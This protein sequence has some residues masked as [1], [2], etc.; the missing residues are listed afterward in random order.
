MSNI[1]D[2]SD[3]VKG[4]VEAVP[5]YQDL[6]QPAMVELGKGVHTLSKT[7]HIALSP[8]AALVWS[9]DQI[10]NYIQK[11]LEKKLEDV[12]T[13]QIVSPAPEIAVPAI[14]A[15]RYTGHREELRE[16]FS[17]LLAKSMNVNTAKIAHPSFVEIIKQLSPDEARIMKLFFNQNPWPILKMRAIQK[18]TSYYS[19]PLVN[20]SL[21]PYKAECEFPE[22]GPSY[23]T[24]LSR[25]GLAETSYNTYN[26]VEN[27]YQSLYEHAEVVKMHEYITVLGKEPQIKQGTI[28]RSPFGRNFFEACIK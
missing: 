22:L 6:L 13:D 15:L 16:M 28:E 12:P 26:V 3:A 20:F 2:T 5:V 17:N 19:E 10:K 9:Y 11:S 27:S 24:N 14:E 7:I 25:L 1:K 8:I 23:L 21:L 4:I 18:G